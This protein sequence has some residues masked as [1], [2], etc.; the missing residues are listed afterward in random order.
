MVLE[1]SKT[2]THNSAAQK[3]REY[4]EQELKN[5]MLRLMQQNGVN[6]NEVQ[7]SNDGTIELSGLPNLK[8]HTLMT[9]AEELGL[10]IKYTKKTLIELC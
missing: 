3:E 4:S 5:I 9:Q 10:S 2:F 1:T 6:T 7:V 8:L